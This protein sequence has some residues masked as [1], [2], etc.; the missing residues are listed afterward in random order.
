MLIICDVHTTDQLKIASIK[1]F[2]VHLQFIR[3]IIFF[4]VRKEYDNL[5]K[6]KSKLDLP[7]FNLYG[8]KGP[9]YNINGSTIIQLFI[10]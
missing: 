4:K 5:R 10:R 2:Q 9:E 7:T 1:Y 8:P 3:M 6:R